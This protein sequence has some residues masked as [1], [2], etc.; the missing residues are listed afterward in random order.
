VKQEW[1]ALMAEM[2]TLIRSSGLPA[3]EVAIS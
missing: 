2:K 3:A 1:G